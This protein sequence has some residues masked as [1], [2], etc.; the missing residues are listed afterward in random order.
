LQ[1]NI[2]LTHQERNLF[3]QEL[4]QHITLIETSLIDLEQN[5]SKDLIEQLFRSFHTIKGNAGMIGYTAMQETA[6]ETEN[7]LQFFRQNEVNLTE[8][9]SETLFDILDYIK[10]LAANLSKQSFEIDNDDHA[11]IIK[12]IKS[13]NN[14]KNNNIEKDKEI[15]EKTSTK[16]TTE[17][18]T[19]PI[20]EGQGI[21]LE[22]FLSDDAEMPAVTFYQII[23]AI[24]NHTEDFQSTPSSNDIKEGKSADIL[25]VM[26]ST[27]FTNEQLNKI[28]DELSIID[29]IKYI[30]KK[31]PVKKREKDN[32]S[33]ETRVLK[34]TKEEL[35]EVQVNINELDDL[36]NQLGEIMIDR[37]KIVDAISNLEKK[38]N[39]DEDITKLSKVSHHLWSSSYRLQ[40]QLTK[41]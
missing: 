1:I 5:Y 9:T 26:F 24:E 23:N 11:E 38:Y 12:T 15:A 34:N 7:I 22:I 35:S 30:R 36:I 39:M 27:S 25:K 33:L 41:R 10:N 2:S 14:E 6:A 31:F 16:S 8:K 37:N 3:N 19:K 17:K 21:S 32:R 4:N 13:T 20:K 18:K 29:D 40:S 28:L